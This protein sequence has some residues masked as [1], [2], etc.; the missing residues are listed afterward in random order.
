VPPVVLPSGGITP[1]PPGPI[2]EISAHGLTAGLALTLCGIL[3]I[4]DRKRQRKG[5]PSATGQ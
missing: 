3:M 4:T 5:M 2:P 1:T